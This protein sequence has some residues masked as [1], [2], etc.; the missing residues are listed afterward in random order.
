MKKY[1]SVVVKYLPDVLIQIGLFFVI[2]NSNLASSI[3]LD[4]EG[5]FFLLALFVGVN[6]LVR[7]YFNS[8]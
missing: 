1:L 5:R 7:R 4:D 8:R 6:I 3:G 2:L